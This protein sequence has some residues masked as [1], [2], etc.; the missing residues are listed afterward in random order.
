MPWP[1]TRDYAAAL[2]DTG[3]CFADDDLIDGQVDT[4]AD[5]LPQSKTGNS[6][7]V[8]KVVKNEKAWAVKCFHWHTDEHQKRYDAIQKALAASSA[9]Y[10]IKM[11][12]LKQGIK[13][14]GVW[15]PVVKMQWVDG[16]TLDNYILNNI[17]FPSRINNVKNSFKLLQSELARNDFGHLDLQHGNIIVQMDRI[18]LVDYDCF[19]VPALADLGSLELGH[20]NYQ[21]PKRLKS[22]NG[23]YLDN[24]SAWVIFASLQCI[25]ID[26]TLWHTL[27]GGDE[28]LLFRSEDYGNPFASYAFAV[29][30]SHNSVEIRTISRLLRSFCELPVTEIP[31]V[32]ETMASPINLKPLP[33]IKTVP[34]WIKTSEGE[35]GDRPGQAERN[36]RAEQV[37]RTTQGM[38][39]G[40]AYAHFRDYNEAVKVPSA[41]FEDAELANAICFLEDT[42]VG[43]NGRIYHFCADDREIAVKCF[44]H[45]VQDRQKHYEAIKLALQ[46]GLRPYVAQVH[47][48]PRGIR[49]GD[50]WFPVVKMDW[51]PGKTLA[52]MKGANVNDATA[53]YLADRFADMMRAFRA[54]GVAHG[55]LALDNIMM[56]GNDLK[57]VDYDG[58]FVPGL[59]RTQALENGNQAFQ[60]P[61]RTLNHFGPYLD[62]FS[63]WIIYYLIKH[64]SVN[65]GLCDLVDACLAD[66]RQTL[67]V[68]SVLR[69][70]ETERPEEVREM[71][72]LLRLLL[73]YKAD[74]V[75]ILEAHADFETALK[76]QTQAAKENITSASP[77]IKRKPR[78]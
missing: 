10:F 33:A 40:F 69:G 15:Y 74:A 21:H 48:L 51:L 29:L 72:R 4:N 45:H 63:S 52:Q 14:D 49:V 12:Y 26:P 17:Q 54:A 31:A 7:S 6:A 24:F 70:L 23:A 41:N 67:I 9:P 32:N 22:H 18:R 1:S 35:R 62:C 76:P 2:T 75:P 47:Y 16:E 53:S 43:R 19:F 27:G 58:M 71:G 57:I 25:G 65:P 44:S 68:R 50:D 46:G 55:D 28:C 78:A 13:T 60:H 38:S 11:Q 20:H 36:D 34:V 5:G 56:V 64:I 37:E 77:F 59:G 73:S 61:G 39:K 66:E 8:F 30:E 3:L 42:I